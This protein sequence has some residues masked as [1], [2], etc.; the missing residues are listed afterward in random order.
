MFSAGGLGLSVGR[1]WLWTAIAEVSQTELVA[2]ALLSA[3][4]FKEV[5]IPVG[6]AVDDRYLLDLGDDGSVEHPR[7]SPS[8]IIGQPL[9]GIRRPRKG[10]SAP[11]HAGRP[12]PRKD[13]R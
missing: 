10:R 7:L 11:A 6:L 13:E 9:H 12:T 1:E 3:S 5:C 4:S 8:P 2:F